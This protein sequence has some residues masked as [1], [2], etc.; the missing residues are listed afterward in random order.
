M[1]VAVV[2]SSLRPVAG[3]GAA[4]PPHPR[5]RRPDAATTP[6]RRVGPRRHPA[7]GPRAPGRGTATAPGPR[8]PRRRRRTPG[9]AADRT[10]AAR[11][12]A[13]RGRGPRASSSPPPPPWRSTPEWASW[14]RTSRSRARA[15]CFSRPPERGCWGPPSS[16]RPPGF[17]GA[18]S[19]SLVM[20]PTSYRSRIPGDRSAGTHADTCP[21]PTRI[22]TGRRRSQTRLDSPRAQERVAG[23]AAT[24]RGARRGLQRREHARADAGP[25]PP[26]LP[27]PDLRADRRRRRVRGRHLRRRQALA[28]AEPAAADHRRAP[29]G[30]PR[31]RRE[32][33]VRLP[34]G[35]RA[36]A[37]TSSCCCT[38]TVSTRRRSSPRSSRR[39]STARPT[40]SSA[41]G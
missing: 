10:G 4:A 21:M 8:R 6:R 36:A 2:G 23:G 16:E 30:E 14:R 12:R 18:A 39:S 37:S 26:R 28:V 34:D 41:P 25:D 11:D 32:P 17:P 7:C 40:P 24:H 33:E 38:P 15:C 3:T 27:R 5:H 22:P 20:R 29:P 31:L 19:S 9:R 1:P 35:H 13:T